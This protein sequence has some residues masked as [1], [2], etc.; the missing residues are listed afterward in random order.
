[1][2]KSLHNA[3]LYLHHLIP[4][5]ESEPCYYLYSRSHNV[6]NLLET[7]NIGLFQLKACVTSFLSEN[8]GST[9][10][11]GSKKQHF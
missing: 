2:Q 3:K 9:E 8:V 1:M 4:R 5:R 6:I 11:I 7:M 10:Q